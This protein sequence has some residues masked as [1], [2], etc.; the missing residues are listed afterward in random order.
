MSDDGL[1]CVRKVRESLTPL[2]EVKGS[3][4]LRWG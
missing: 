2:D 3:A 1:G 4:I